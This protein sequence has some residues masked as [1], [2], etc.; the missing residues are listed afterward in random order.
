MKGYKW[1]I[2]VFAI[3]LTLYFI[4]EANRPEPIEWD[5]S[6]SR[7]DKNPYGTYILYN[8]LK[9][10][11]PNTRVQSSRLTAYDQ[12]G[13]Y[14]TVNSAYMLIAPRLMF[15]EEDVNALLN[16]VVTGNYVFISS[17]SISDAF[18]DSMHLSVARTLDFGKKDSSSLNFAS[19]SLKA[20]KNYTFQRM[21]LD[22]YLQKYDT[23]YSVILGTN[24][25]R[26]PVF[27]KMPYGE[28]AFF[29]SVN[30]LT[31]SNYFMLTGN[32]AEY[33]AKALSY[34]PGNIN[35][36]IWDEYYKLGAEG[37]NNPLRFIL[38]DPFLGWSFRLA[39]LAMLVFVLFQGKRKQRVIPVMGPLKNTTLEFVRTVGNVYFNKR[40]NRNI[41]EKK[42]SYFLEFLRTRF[43]VNTVQMDDEFAIM[44]AKKAGVTEKDV[45]KLMEIITRVQRN[46]AT[47]D[48]NLLELNEQIDDFYKKAK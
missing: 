11:F 13:A 46:K 31:F 6:L 30:P 1:F 32:N 38:N 36:I 22:A 43:Y 42:I 4:A 21:T 33:T 20:S 23:A 29:I 37:A 25:S 2:V 34:L 18:K 47:S 12:V 7:E 24:Q 5:I 27:I 15:S 3:V 44:L 16:Y 45:R 40:D 14:D 39:I 28:G 35:E 48:E 26:A 10:I 41:A 9:N 19:P 8:Q 17:G